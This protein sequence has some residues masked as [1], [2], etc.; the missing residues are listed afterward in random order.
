MCGQYPADYVFVELRPK[1]V[2]RQ[3]RDLRT[4]NAWIALFQFDDRPGQFD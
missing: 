2:R 1:S 4:A 3:L